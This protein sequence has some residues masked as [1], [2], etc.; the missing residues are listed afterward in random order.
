MLELMVSICARRARRLI[1]SLP[2][3]LLR[4]MLS[5]FPWAIREMTFGSADACECVSFPHHDSKRRTNHCQGSYQECRGELLNTFCWPL[6]QTRQNER[7]LH[8]LQVSLVPVDWKWAIDVLYRWRE[9]GL[10]SPWLIVL[11][12]VASAL[13]PKPAAWVNSASLR[14]PIRG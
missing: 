10:Q 1:S 3:K 4:E 7:C 11:R 14:V 8:F 5:A 9:V 2:I 6:L 13:I 12:C